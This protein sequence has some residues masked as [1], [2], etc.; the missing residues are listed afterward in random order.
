MVYTCDA[1]LHGQIQAESAKKI[2]DQSFLSEW[3]QNPS[4]NSINWRGSRTGLAHICFRAPKLRQLMSLKSAIG[5]RWED[6]MRSVR[7]TWSLNKPKLWNAVKGLNDI[8]EIGD[9]QSNIE[10][11]HHLEVDSCSWHCCNGQWE[12]ESLDICT[13]LPVSLPLIDSSGS[14]YIWILFSL[15]NHRL[16]VCSYS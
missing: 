9:A 2:I 11:V 5:T 15:S 3:L 13:R 12:C 1:L 16:L 6:L 14:P 8:K 7:S 10:R 4:S